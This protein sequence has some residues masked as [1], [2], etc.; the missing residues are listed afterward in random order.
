MKSY[1]FFGL[2]RMINP[3]V[4]ELFE[5]KYVISWQ[6]IPQGIIIIE[7]KRND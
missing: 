2:K 3:E 1:G 4:K 6:R 7:V 5:K